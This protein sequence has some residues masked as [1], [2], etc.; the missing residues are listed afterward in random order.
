MPAGPRLEVVSSSRS[1][2]HL[3]NEVSGA[4]VGTAKAPD[5][6]SYTR[7]PVREAGGSAEMGRPMQALLRLGT[8]WSVAG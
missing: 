3:Q 2:M 8:D 1:V 4:Q 6:T 5:G 7:P